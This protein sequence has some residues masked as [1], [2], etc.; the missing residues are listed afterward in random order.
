[1]T[2]PYAT[3]LAL[4]PE[5]R[6]VQ[7]AF[8]KLQEIKADHVVALMVHGW[9]IEGYPPPSSRRTEMVLRWLDY[10]TLEERHD[11]ASD[12]MEESTHEHVIALDV[13]GGKIVSEDASLLWPFD[14]EETGY[15][16]PSWCEDSASLPGAA[17]DGVAVGE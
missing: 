1:M 11:W 12:I 14:S 4:M 15:P 3:K 9:K 7:R 13:Y 17:Q 6:R 2:T 10:R 16:C 5:S 8:G